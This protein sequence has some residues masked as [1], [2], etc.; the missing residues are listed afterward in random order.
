VL[1]T[2]GSLI[3]AVDSKI[4]YALPRQRMLRGPSQAYLR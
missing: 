4:P 3:N 2:N 1:T